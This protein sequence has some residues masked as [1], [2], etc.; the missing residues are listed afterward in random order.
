MFLDREKKK[1]DD[2]IRAEQFSKDDF[3]N[4]ETSYEKTVEELG[5]QQTKRDQI[6]ALYLSILG[7][8]IPNI[9]SL[10]IVPIGKGLGFLVIY[11][12][13]ILLC[14]IVIRYRI[15][16]EVY[17]ISCRVISQLYN[18]VPELRNKETVQTLFFR[19]LKKNSSNVV[20]KNRSGKVST[21]KSFKKQLSSAEMTLFNILL[22]FAS[23]IGGISATYLWKDGS[24][25]S[26]IAAGVLVLVIIYTFCRLNYQYV[27]S[28]LLQYKCVSTEK[29]EDLSIPFNKAWMLHC[30]I[31][32]D[33]FNPENNEE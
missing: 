6:I 9:I 32:D 15:Y 20:V 22:I 1:I 31:D 19:S 24:V 17:W 4:L 14:R 5:L 18:I 28:L 11:I 29:T 27:S 25:Y 13:G 12:I 21:L 8:V 26:M 16:K 7:F 3:M 2:K 23:F 30:Y 33:E 10:D